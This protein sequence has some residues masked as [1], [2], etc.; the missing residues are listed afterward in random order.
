MK[1]ELTVADVDGKI[2]TDCEVIVGP[3]RASI[4]D[5]IRQLEVFMKR[6]S[7]ALRMVDNTARV[8]SVPGLKL[9]PGTGRLIAVPFPITELNITHT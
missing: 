9:P 4:A 3:D 8:L 2:V 7:E 5:D 1:L 6:M